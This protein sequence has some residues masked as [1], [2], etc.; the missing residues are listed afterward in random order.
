[1]A[2]PGHVHQGFFVCLRRFL[3]RVAKMI[4]AVSVPQLCMHQPRM[5]YESVCVHELV[6]EPETLM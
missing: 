2:R 3:N 4:D 1:M 5:Q 6:T